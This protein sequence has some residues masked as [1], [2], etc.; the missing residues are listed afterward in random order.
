[1]GNVVVAQLV[2]EFYLIDPEGKL[3]H[4]GSWSGPD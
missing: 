4:Y 1:M 3:S 2:K